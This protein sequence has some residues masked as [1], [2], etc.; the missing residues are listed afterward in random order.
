[1][2]GVKF[3]RSNPRRLAARFAKDESGVILPLVGLMF[4]ALLGLAA[5]ALDIPRYFDLQT[6]LQKGA[7]ACALAAAAELDGDADAIQRAQN[8]MDNLVGS[9]NSSWAGVVQCQTPTFYASLPASDASPM[10][11]PTADPNAARFAEVTTTPTSISSF[12][13]LTLLGL[14][15]NV[16]T[17]R[18]T[19]V[20]GFSET[21]CQSSPIFVCNGTGVNDMT[22]EATM[23]GKEVALVAPPGTGFSPGNFGFLNVG[24]TGA[25]CLDKALGQDD[26]GLCINVN[27][28]DTSTGQKASTSDYFNTRFGLYENNAKSADPN[29]FSPDVNVRDGYV[30]TSKGGGSSCSANQTPGLTPSTACP[31][32]DDSSISSSFCNGPGTYGAAA[33]GNGDWQ[34]NLSAY[35][36]ANYGTGSNAPPQPAASSVPTRYDL[37]KYE[38]STTFKGKSLLSIKSAGGETGAP[39]CYA[40]QSNRRLLYAAVVDCSQL[41]GGR[42]NVRPEG[43]ATFFLLQPAQG[44]GFGTMLGEYVG[45]S[46]P[47]DASGI[48]HDVSQLYR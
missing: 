23:K 38:N 4:V 17:A 11:A 45:Y 14:A 27:L 42:T 24:C 16:L 7:D 35:W 13:P 30:P 34:S 6:Q 44:S 39:L 28:I 22:D 18:A 12:L 46:A 43:V 47:N 5:F 33:I 3:N 10:G 20:A 31:Y 36:S 40:G 9:A 26:N 25:Q 29:L 1:M 2:I 32:P 21:I 48:V 15:N 19:A 37:Y 41:G 8:A